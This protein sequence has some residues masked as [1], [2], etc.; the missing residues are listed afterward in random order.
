VDELTMLS[1]HDPAPLAQFC[2]ANGIDP[3]WARRFPALVLRRGLSPQ[4]AFGELPSEVAE[5]FATNVACHVLSPPVVTQSLRDGA[6][7]LV[8]KTAGELSLETVLLRPGTGRTSVCI[9]SQVGCAAKCTFC[10]TGQMAIVKN[11]TRD[12]IL[13]QVVWANELLV[14]EKRR[15][16]NVVFMGMGEPL[17]NEEAVFAAVDR[18]I[19]RDGFSLSP[20]R[21]TVS[22]VGVP[23]GMIRLAETFPSIGIALSLHSAR[24]DARK[25]IVPLAERYSLA[26]LRETVSR[27]NTIQNQPVMLECL[28]LAGVTDTDEDIA[29]LLDFTRGL[30]VHVNLIPFNAIDSPTP[31]VASHPDRIQKIANALKHVG[32]HVTVRYSLGQDIAAACGQLVRPEHR[33]AAIQAAGTSTR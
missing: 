7:K 13:D 30:S 32:L 19:S 16:R 12:E 21:V 27:L 9:S 22:S 24:D 2:R 28:M 17:H 4:A 25:Q 23:S 6:T 29:A 1:I 31:L 26:E 3:Y 11:L 15:V 5:C 10:A 33:R 14:A 8:L 18:L 20:R